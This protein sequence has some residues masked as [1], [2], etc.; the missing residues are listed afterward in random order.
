MAFPTIES[1]ES[2]ENVAGKQI[3]VPAWLEEVLAEA[4]RR[5]RQV[6]IVRAVTPIGTYVLS[7]EI[8]P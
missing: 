2:P 5:Q 1:V 8:V 4:Q 3:M 7:A 6:R